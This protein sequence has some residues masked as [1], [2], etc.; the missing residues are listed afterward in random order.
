M[1]F[2]RTDKI[3][4]K[5]RW[6][7]SLKCKQCQVSYE[8]V[9]GNKAPKKD[10][11]CSADCRREW[12]KATRRM[13]N[14]KQC[15]LEFYQV[16]EA[17]LFCNNECYHKHMKSNPDQYNLSEKAAKARSNSNTSESIQKMKE[18]KLASGNMI[19]WKDATWKQYWKKCD[20]ITRKIRS[21]MLEQWDGRD[22]ITGEYIKDN[23][24]LHFS[25]GDYPTLDHVVSKTECYKQGLTPQQACSAGNLKWTTR[26]NNS[27]KY[28]KVA[29]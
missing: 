28:N 14:C 17:K 13:S 26:R 15:D 3:E 1:T 9:A 2:V 18:T 16:N 29:K 19:D 20:E 24:N 22:Y 27:S 5:Y 7:H 4:G 10:G 21:V 6:I 25:H 11:W 23:L 12:H 8:R